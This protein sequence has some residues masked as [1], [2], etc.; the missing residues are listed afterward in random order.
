M[1]EDSVTSN[2]SSYNP[3][4]YQD[5]ISNEN[6]EYTNETIEQSDSQA[7]PKI[8]PHE[9]QMLYP[10]HIQKHINRKSLNMKRLIQTLKTPSKHS[11]GKEAKR[12]SELAKFQESL[13][14]KLEVQ[15]SNKKRRLM[16]EEKEIQTELSDKGIEIENSNCDISKVFSLPIRQKAQ[17]QKENQ[18]PLIVLKQEP[19]HEHDKEIIRA[20]NFAEEDKIDCFREVEDFNYEEELINNGNECGLI[21][22]DIQNTQSYNEDI[23]KST[24]QQKLQF[25]EKLTGEEKENDV[26]R[27]EEENEYS[28]GYCHS[29]AKVFHEEYCDN[30]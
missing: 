29:F 1:F 7:S 23:L 25:L 4:I 6:K 30:C 17:K 21:F 3:V 2:Q 27:Q 8:F 11:C 10:K 19:I 24:P 9:M 28:L 18:S 5:T 22:K 16:E 14:Y 26:F 20:I 13:Y 12:M 15:S